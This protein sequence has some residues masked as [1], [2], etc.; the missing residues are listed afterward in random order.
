MTDYMK[1]GKTIKNLCTPAYIYIFISAF[2][3]LFALFS[4]F[5]IVAVLNKAFLLFF[6]HTY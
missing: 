4:G 3:I 2:A 5:G 6:G 1:L